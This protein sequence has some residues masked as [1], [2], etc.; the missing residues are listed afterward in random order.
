MFRSKGGSRENSWKAFV[1][2]QAR[3]GGSLDQGGGGGNGEKNPTGAPCSAQA[4]FLPRRWNQSVLTN[5]QR[6]SLST[7]QDSAGSPL[8]GSLLWTM[9]VLPDLSEVVSVFCTVR[10]TPDSS[11]W[12][13]CSPV[14][15]WRCLHFSCCLA[16][17]LW[18]VNALLAFAEWY[19]QS[20]LGNYTCKRLLMPIAF[21]SP[22]LNTGCLYLSS[23]SCSIKTYV[24]IFLLLPLNSFP[25]FS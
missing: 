2:V 16:F 21:A 12:L 9:Q 10:L 17:S 5:L 4:Q 1:A 24:P 3:S 18:K 20:S 8:P 19:Q 11:L 23:R 13:G 7:L 15:F 6:G 22:K 25:Y 14:H